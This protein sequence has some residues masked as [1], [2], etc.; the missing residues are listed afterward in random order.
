MNSYEESMLPF[1]I[2]GSDH[3]S[4][5]FRGPTPGSADDPDLLCDT[6]PGRSR[7]QPQSHDHRSGHVPPMSDGSPVEGNQ[8]VV[9]TTMT[10]GSGADN[11]PGRFRPG[12]TY[13]PRKMGFGHS[14]LNRCLGRLP[15][16]GRHVTMAG[17]GRSGSSVVS[18]IFLPH[19]Q[20]SPLYYERPNGPLSR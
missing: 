14:G 15:L 17:P 7:A 13:C 2:Y 12:T 5:L 6:V 19:R 18:N 4:V 16:P 9:T 10:S 20:T 8:R 11:L 1:P 3:T